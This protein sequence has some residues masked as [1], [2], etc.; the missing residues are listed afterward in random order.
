[1]RQK[2]LVIYGGTFFGE[3]VPYNP[4][5]LILAVVHGNLEQ[6]VV[7]FVVGDDLSGGGP[8]SC[9]TLDLYQPPTNT[10]WCTLGDLTLDATFG[11][12][13]LHHLQTLFALVA[14][15]AE[16]VDHQNLIAHV[17]NV[18]QGTLAHGLKL[19]YEMR[20]QELG[21]PLDQITLPSRETTFHH[22]ANALT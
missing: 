16:S 12:E 22:P 2:W 10:L 5:C 4:P 6:A 1:M 11:Q 20:G 3:D 19:T 14:E 7:E 18:G 21:D 8:Q 9:R 15:P 17:A 13:L